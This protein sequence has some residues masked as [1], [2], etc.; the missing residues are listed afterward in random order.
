[1]TKILSQ[2]EVDSLLKGI[3]EGKI[4][5]Q[6][7]RVEENRDLSPYDFHR[8]HGPLLQRIPGIRAIMERFSGMVRTTLS[9]ASGSHVAVNPPVMSTVAFGEFCRSLSLPASFN[10]FKME[11]MRGASMMVL[12][13]ALVFAFVDLFLGGRGER[14]FKVEGKSFTPI[15]LKII[16]KIVKGLLE[17]FGQ[18]WSE[19]QKLHA[20]FI[21][22][23]IDP[24]FA[25]IARPGDVVLVGQFTIEI[26]SFSGGM[27]ICMP[28]AILEPIR[29]KLRGG[30][31]GES[32]GVDER[33]RQ[34]LEKKIFDL[35]VNVSCTLGHSHITG[36]HLLGMKVNEVLPL[37]QGPDD[38][39]VICVEG[40]PKFKGHLGALRQNKAIRVDERLN[41]E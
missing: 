29:G 14:P 16:E 2:E 37:E 9:A 39:V 20:A 8:E 12:E 6:G 33:W 11:P 27:M 32:M 17:G 25:E 35:K 5:G 28:Y 41:R 31:K 15:E 22:C 10:L 21:R 40:V 7:E 13:G 36:R 34:Y 19:V 30:F 18:A 26:G 24:Q 3:D 1:M 23:E 4:S 38:P